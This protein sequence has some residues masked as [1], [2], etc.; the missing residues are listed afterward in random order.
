MPFGFVRRSSAST[1][2]CGRET[3]SLRASR[4]L[5][6]SPAYTYTYNLSCDT[7]CV[8]NETDSVSVIVNPMTAAITPPA[9]NPYMCNNYTVGWGSAGGATTCTVA[10]PLCGPP[11]HTGGASGTFTENEENPDTY[12][13]NLSC[14]NG[15]GSVPATDTKDVTV[16]EITC[17]PTVVGSLSPV[18]MGIGYGITS[19][20]TANHGTVNEVDFIASPTIN[21]VARVCNIAS[22]APP[23]LCAVGED[24]TYTDTTSPFGANVSIVNHNFTNSQ[25]YVRGRM[26]AEC[27][28][29][30]FDI[31][32]DDEILPVDIA[33]TENW[34]QVANGN[35]TAK[36]GITSLLPLLAYDQHFI[37]KSP[38]WENIGLLTYRLFDLATP[39]NPLP[40]NL[41]GATNADNYNRISIPKI[42][43]NTTVSTKPAA[44][45]DL[46]FNQ[47]LPADIKAEVMDII[48]PS[49]SNLAYEYETNNMP[50]SN[51]SLCTKM[52]GYRVCYYDG[53]A[54]PLG[55]P[56][57][58]LT[59]TGNYVIAD[60]DRIILY[61][62]NAKVTIGNATGG[63]IRPLT[64]G[65]S[66][67]LLIS[68]GDISIDY[69]VG[70]SFSDG[71]PDLEGVFYTDGNFA[72]GSDP[73]TFTEENLHIRGSVVAGS[74]S[75]QRDLVQGAESNET[76]PGEYFTYGTEQVMAFPPFLKLHP[77]FWQE[78]NP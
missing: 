51:L 38:A 1:G 65:K 71:I 76:T 3:S 75:L 13:Y 41:G 25:L 20:F 8:A 11:D 56:L 77:S 45:F 30:G 32:C 26:T 14:T 59:L 46:F 70:S 55:T 12:T 2:N 63:F 68:S 28:A 16:D 18:S 52:K 73:I 69:H 39:P 10:C 27:A 61:V 19:T 78:V 72:T 15:C 40:P 4:D 37:V 43:S 58:D 23:A 21:S 31:P 47:K 54:A 6:K 36:G 24:Y 66:S 42:S 22:P 29:Y 57:G 60:T 9:T 35:V 5:F 44:S 74:F 17:T 53:D 48:T 34:F 7:A 67:F 62:D 33:Y 49:P 50:L 64:R